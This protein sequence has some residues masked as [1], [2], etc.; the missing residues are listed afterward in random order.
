MNLESFNWS[1]NYKR[2]KK[3]KFRARNNNNDWLYFNSDT[4]WIKISELKDHG[5]S[6]KKACMF[7]DPE[8]VDDLIES[9]KEY[10]KRLNEDA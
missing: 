6:R 5:F 10:K 8:S 4:G 3:M 7:L 1:L 2:K 9:L